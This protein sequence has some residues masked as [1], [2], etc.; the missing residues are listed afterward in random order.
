MPADDLSWLTDDEEFNPEDAAEDAQG[1][2]FGPVPK[3]EYE[4]EVISAEER[5]IDSDNGTG[6]RVAVQ[7]AVRGDSYDNRRI[8]ESFNV[9]YKS[10]KDT[11]EARKKAKKAQQIGRGQFGALCV[12]LG[13]SKRPGSYSEL[14][15]KY[16]RGKVGI[17]E[18][19]GEKQNNVKSFKE[20]KQFTNPS[21]PSASDSSS[22]GSGGSSGG[23]GGNP[24]T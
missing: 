17:E 2:E 21:R 4:L 5:E 6:T 9:L 22:G 16:C 20:S 1:G 10:K 12:A 7:F 14:V 19:N 15:G 24:W 3:G 8:W 18:W 23:G 11:A 13:I